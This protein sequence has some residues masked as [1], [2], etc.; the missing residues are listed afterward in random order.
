MICEIRPT[1]PDDPVAEALIAELSAALDDPRQPVASRHGYSV[2]RLVA[3]RVA[4]FVAWCADA[5]AGCAGLARA[6]D[7]GEVKRMYVRPAFRRRGVAQA[8]LDELAAQARAAALPRLRLETGIWQHEAIAF[9]ERSGFS[10]TGPF[11]PYREDPF[12]V[13]F[14]RP[15]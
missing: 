5:P 9:Y 15:L 6:A 7:Y 4:F 3:E 14:E 12:S 10:R 11:G 2:A 8:L 1:P 13:Y